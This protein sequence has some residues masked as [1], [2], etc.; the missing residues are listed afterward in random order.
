VPGDH[1]AADAL[2]TLDQKIQVEQEFSY[3][4]LNV[5]YPLGVFALVTVG[6]RAGGRWVLAATVAAAALWWLVFSRKAA[7]PWRSLR[8]T[9]RGLVIWLSYNPRDRVF[10]GALRLPAPWRWPWVARVLFVGAVV[11][12]YL[13]LL[14][15]FALPLFGLP[16]L[17]AVEFRLEVFPMTNPYPPGSV[18]GRVV[19]RHNGKDERI[20][21]RLEEFRGA[22]RRGDAQ[23]RTGHWEDEDFTRE[24]IVPPGEYRPQPRAEAPPPGTPGAADDPNNP[25]VRFGPPPG[26]PR[27]PDPRFR[28]DVDALTRV[29]ELENQ[30]GR[31]E[32]PPATGPGP[33]PAELLAEPAAPPGW[34]V[35]VLAVA[36][37]YL[38]L[39]LGPPAACFALLWFTAGNAL[40]AYDRLVQDWAE[41]N[42]LPTTST[43]IVSYTVPFDGRG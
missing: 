34:A 12:C 10:P 1:A 15:P 33:T 27:R 7:G 8:A 37:F 43:T 39:T 22:M 25:K 24:N 40:A 38:V 4:G 14:L 42:W 13:A 36:A 6:P 18:L 28:T 32:W 29:G 30:I 20:A 31:G 35:G 11:G 2:V 19:E 16:R 21:R 5:A 9:W 41:T 17:A 26:L 23:A 3:W